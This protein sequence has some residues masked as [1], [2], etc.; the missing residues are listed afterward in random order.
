MKKKIEQ[1]PVDLYLVDSKGQGLV[2]CKGIKSF[3][4]ILP[5]E[6]ILR[7]HFQKERVKLQIALEKNEKYTPQPL[8]LE[9]ENSIFVAIVN[10]AAK[11]NN[12]IRRDFLVL[13]LGNKMPCCIIGPQQPDKEK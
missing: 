5:T 11:K 12:K 1:K 4:G 3:V 13:T 10:E 8:Y 2:S 6:E 9:I 7:T